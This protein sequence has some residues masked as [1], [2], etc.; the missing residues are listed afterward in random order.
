MRHQKTFG[1][2]FIEACKTRTED[3]NTGSFIP[4]T[5]ATG[6]LEQES[7]TASLSREESLDLHNAVITGKFYT[8]TQNV[9]DGIL[10]SGTSAEFPFDVAHDEVEIIRQT[11]A[12]SFI[13]GRSGTGKTTCL[14]FKLLSNYIG[15]RVTSGCKPIRQVFITRS[16]ILAGKLNGYIRRLVN[17]Q[18]GRFD[19]D[20]VD[21]I[22]LEV[23]K[24]KEENTEDCHL[25]S[26]KEEDFP[27]VCTFDKLLSMVET[28]LKKSGRNYWKASE[29][30]S[31]TAEIHRRRSS[32][33][34]VPTRPPREVDAQT[35][36]Q[37]YWSKF[38]ASV[39][40]SI[41][42]DLVFSEI[43]GIIKGSTSA[44]PGRN[45]R[46]LT[47]EE[48]LGRSFR[49]AP[50]FTSDIERRQVYTIY[51]HYERLKAEY[52]DWDGVDRTRKVFAQ[53]Q[54]N[55]AIVAKLKEVVDEIY[56]DGL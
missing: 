56:V 12:A 19:S 54:E 45:L 9:L 51:E 21:N 5:F 46:A 31:A 42:V 2:E 39:R 17:C 6:L 23:L 8:L 37:D 35:F 1:K 25:W 7:V 36:I 15:S 28:S 53:L 14:A 13:L 27:L 34:A 52:H 44:L 49:I 10:T 43:M 18:L 30:G 33:V 16:E 40:L 22:R 48:Y 41:P 4:Q 47:K 20:D 50:L 3:R 11:S 24:E 55:P 26:L 38:P 29:P 32:V